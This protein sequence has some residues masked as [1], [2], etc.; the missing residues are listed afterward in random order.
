MRAIFD[1]LTFKSGAI[2]PNR[3]MLA[4]LTNKQS[5]DDGTLSEEEYRWLTL[6]AEGGFGATMTCAANVQASG[7]GFSGQLGCFGDEHLPGLSR[8]AESIKSEG[9]LALLQLHHAGMRSPQGLIGEKPHCPSE[10]EKFGAR[11]LSLDEV[12]DLRDSFIAA[13]LR[14]DRAGFDG[15]ELHAAHG[16]IL[17]QFLSAT[18][19]RR[20]DEYGGSLANRGRLL[21]EIVDG[22]RQQCREE[23]TLGVRLSPERFDLKLGEIREL[24]QELIHDDK[25]D[26]LDMSLWDAFKNPI[27]KE[28]EGRTLLSWFAELDRGNVRLGVAGKIRTAA[29]AHRC[30]VAGADFVLLGHSAIL[31]YDFP[32]RVLANHNFEPVELPVTPSYLKAEGLSDVFIDYLSSWEGFIKG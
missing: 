6:R 14:A 3:F 1:K 9:S 12:I 29:D 21:K 8:L 4:P 30:L 5:C 11:A 22:V 7:R 18:I 19:N 10:N 28:Y 24:A 2:M 31:H 20:N 27:E 25:I 32:Q 23:F 26:F 15:I 16:Y 13:A 17:A